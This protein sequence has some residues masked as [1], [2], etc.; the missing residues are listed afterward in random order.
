MPTSLLQLHLAMWR[1]SN[2]IT[3]FASFTTKIEVPPTSI[4]LQKIERNGVLIDRD[5]LATQSRMKSALAFLELEQK[6]YELAGA[7]V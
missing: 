7:T 2:T 3:S 4:V 6:A 1:K 5:L